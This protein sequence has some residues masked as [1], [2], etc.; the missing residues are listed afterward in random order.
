MKK[1]FDA[2]AYARDG[3]FT[4]FVDGFLKKYYPDDGERSDKF[5]ELSEYQ[6]IGRMEPEEVANLAA[7]LYGDEAS[8]ITGGV[9]GVDGGTMNLR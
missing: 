8:F 3:S 9:Y 4:P 1:A 6:Q 5:K 2:I 7:F